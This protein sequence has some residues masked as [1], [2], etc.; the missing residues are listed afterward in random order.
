MP[1]DLV[2]EGGGVKGIGL[3]GAIAGLEE[4]G[5]RFERMAG[6]SAGAIVATLLASG[7]TAG[8]V[9]AI[10]QSLE[11]ERF[12]DPT[13]QTRL[14]LVG[15]LASLLARQG[16]YTGDYLHQV[17]HHYLEAKGVR[18]FGDLHRLAATGDDRD[19]YAAQVIASDITGRR[20]LVLPRDARKLGIEPDELRVAD[21]VRMSMSIPIF[22]TPVRVNRHLIVDGGLLSNFPVWLFDSEDPPRWPTFGLKLVEPHPRASIGARFSDDP[23]TPH[24]ISAIVDYAKGLIATMSEFHDRLYLESHTFARTIAIPTLG[25]GTTDFGLTP[26]Q[27]EQLYQAGRTAAEAFLAS[28]DFAAYIALF[29]RGGERRSLAETLR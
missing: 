27:A 7:Y 8:E 19:R 12:K 5:Y 14:P 21:A 20:L 2:C 4:H 9:R 1:V 22:F 16:L 18:A 15:G 26:E 25:I 10:I 3:V 17:M 24:G 13:W 28:W 29:R 6:T 11:F 23:R